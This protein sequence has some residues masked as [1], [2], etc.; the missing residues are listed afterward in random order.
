[1]DTISVSTV[2]AS[3]TFPARASPSNVDM[4]ITTIDMALHVIR[5]GRAPSVADVEADDADNERKSGK[6]HKV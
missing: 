2:P 4:A 3:A 1:M 6:R 5:E